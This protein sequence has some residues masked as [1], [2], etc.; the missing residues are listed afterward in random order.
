MNPLKTITKVFAIPFVDEKPKRH[1]LHLFFGKVG[2]TATTRIWFV[3]GLPEVD[4]LCLYIDEN[5]FISP[6][7]KNF[8]SKIL[9]YNIHHSLCREIRNDEY[10]LV[11]R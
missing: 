9:N 2:T 8:S 5:D 10:I 4:K 7:D 11:D 3:D 6:E 1:K